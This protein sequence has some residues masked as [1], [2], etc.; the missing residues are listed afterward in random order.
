MVFHGRV[1][2]LLCVYAT[3][4]EWYTLVG[5]YFDGSQNCNFLSNEIRGLDKIKFVKDG[6]HK[7]AI[8]RRKYYFILFINAW[9][10]KKTKAL[11]WK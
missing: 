6:K 8:C 9:L 7:S 11:N 3:W 10:N 5:P 1:L 2:Y 4:S